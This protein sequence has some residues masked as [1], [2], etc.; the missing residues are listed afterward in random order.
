MNT[1]ELAA[2]LHPWMVV[3]TWHTG[4]PSD[5][6]RFHKALHG[7]F[8]DFG[9]SISYDDFKEAMQ[10]IAMKRYPNFKSEYLNELIEEKA[11]KAEIIG[12]YLYDISNP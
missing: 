2:V 5:E 12:S 8:R 7:A 11:L 10:S 9:Y 6:R 4:H 1:D 3:E